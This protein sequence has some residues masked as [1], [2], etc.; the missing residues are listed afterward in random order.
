MKTNKILRNLYRAFAWL[1]IPGM[2]IYAI[3]L[4]VQPSSTYAGM[5]VLNVFMVASTFWALGPWFEK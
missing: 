1:A 3:V 5:L 4:I 2:F